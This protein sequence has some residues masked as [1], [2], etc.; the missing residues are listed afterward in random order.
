VGVVLEPKG[1]NGF[2]ATVDWWDIK[3]N[4]AIA[5]IGAQ[6]VIDTCIATGDRDFCNRIHRDPNGSLWLGNGQI[7]DRQANIGGLHVRGID[8]GADYSAH[9]GHLGSAI[10]E[11]RGSYVLHWITDKGG[12]SAPYDCVGRFG[13]PCGIQPRWKHSARATWNARLGPSLSLQWRHTGGMNLAALDPKFNLTNTV[14][15]ADTK[16]AAQD[17]FDVTTVFRVG[18]Q[19]ELRLGVNNVLD[20]QPP[21]I[22][23]NTAA[24]GG[25]ANGNTYPEWYDALGRYI[26]ASAAM[27]FRP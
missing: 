17:Y 13:D 6:S 26:F 24:G 5:Q 21:L 1:V 4:G 9:L 22:V 25:P 15:T 27:N 19:F 3:L 7:D 8:V 23:R 12:L 10:I 11:F 14:S 18:K 20:R 16:L 2:N